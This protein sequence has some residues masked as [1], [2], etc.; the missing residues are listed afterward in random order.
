VIRAAAV[1]AMGKKALPSAVYADFNSE[2]PDLAQA[3]QANLMSRCDPQSH[4][5]LKSALG[6]RLARSAALHIIEEC[7]FS[8]LAKAVF[9]L[10]NHEKNLMV[11]ARL[12]L[13]LGRLNHAPSFAHIHT[14]F[15][16]TFNAGRKLPH[17]G[18]K[19]Y[20]AG[21]LL[22]ALNEFPA[23]NLHP[24]WLKL[25]KNPLPRSMWSVI[26]PIL[27]HKCPPWLKKMAANPNDPLSAGAFR[28]LRL[29]C[30]WRS[31]R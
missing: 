4:S 25:L 1:K 28:S 26:T 2:I 13:T 29:Q 8:P 19:L 23:Q 14:L 18:K 21:T 17:S 6:K 16:E 9:K 11:K 12:A 10:F 15:W 3:V 31:F 27:G 24:F 30:G 20:A 22:E 7:R 5:L